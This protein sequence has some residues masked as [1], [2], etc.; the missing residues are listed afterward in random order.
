MAKH[1]RKAKVAVLIACTHRDAASVLD[2]TELRIMYPY[3]C[4]SILMFWMADVPTSLSRISFSSA[5]ILV[6]MPRHLRKM[7]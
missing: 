2:E 7:F 6:Q 5:V 1:G 3:G 4:L